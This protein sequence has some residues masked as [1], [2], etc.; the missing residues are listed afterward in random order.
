MPENVAAV[1]EAGWVVPV[2]PP[3]QVLTDHALVVDR[4]VIRDIL[5]AAQACERY[6]GAVETRLPGHVL[7]PGLIN[8]HTHA[9]MA[10]MRGLA[11]DRA[12]MDWLKNYIWPAELKLVSPEFVEDGTLLACAEMLRGGIT[13]FN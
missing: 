3:G 4:G 10:L 9:A 12:L 7:I 13:C 5:P 11:D 1:I 6:R 8:L 2:D